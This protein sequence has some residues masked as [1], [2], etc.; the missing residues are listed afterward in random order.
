M[1][2]GGGG[3]LGLSEIGAL[4]WFEEHHIP[5]DVIAG[6]SMGGMISA[7]YA[8]GNSIDQLKAVM[9]DQ[10]FGS[11]FRI[12]TSYASRSFRRREDSRDLPNGLTI[13]LKHGV[14][15]RNSVLIDQGLNSFLDREFLR[16][17]DQVDFNTLP[18][19]FRCLSTD[20][21]EA[22]TV[23][24]ARGSIPDAVRASISIPGIY[25]PFEM[26]G[27][28]YVDGAVLQNLPAQTVR[29]DLGADVVIAVSLPLVPVGKKDLDSIVGVLQRSFSVAIEGNERA[30]RKLAD[31]VVEPDLTGFSAGDYL[32]SAEL[33]E[34]GYAAAEKMKDSLLPYAVD[35]AAWNAYLA[36][37]TAR[38]RGPAG[39]LLRVRVAAP[40]EGVT[41][42]VER[43]FAPLIDQPVATNKVESLLAA[44]RSD[45][46]YDADYTVGY[47]KGPDRRPVLL[48]TVQDKKTGP[49]FLEL[50]A[51]VAAQTGGISRATIEGILLDQDF[52]GYGS[53]LRS[54]IKLGYLTDFD[55]EY[56]RKVPNFLQIR[57]ASPVGTM[58]VAPHGGILR[59]P[60]PIYQGKTRVSERELQKAGGGVDI[61]W[62]DGRTTE[63]R[64]GWEE[65]DIRWH[66][67]IGI[68]DGL[69][70]VYGSMQRARV[71]YAL[72][73][74]D[75]AFVPQFGYRVTAEGGY[76]YDAAGGA[77]APVFD[78]QITLGHKFGKEIVAFGT[79]GGTMFGRN[80]AQPYRFT[81]G[82]PLRLSASALDELRGTDYFLVRPVIL[83]KVAS[84]PAVLGQSI[85]VGAAYEAGQ[86]RAPDFRTATRQDVFLGVLAET[87]AG[88]ISFGPALGDGGRYKLIF[89][90]GKLF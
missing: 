59:Q 69:P 64:A 30:S 81:L 61:G 63:I 37:R 54:H 67:Q 58:F 24:F 76:L 3:A 77:N 82:G 33:A 40:N 53:E 45:G 27:H 8:T 85:Y 28:E 29:N 23:T 71:R 39:T 19:P 52:G 16:Y 84:L 36:Q 13:G 14:S 15:F 25:R 12:S 43:I 2:L 20:L 26:N 86:M 70:N 11:V 79:E 55:S 73:R 80:V 21:N 41:K 46:R 5:V 1:A 68:Q 60:F 78:T 66:E 4:Q 35:D 75:K 18:I 90:L 62:T 83:R 6:T 56:F 38:K 50:G 65:N 22:R 48:V 34:R 44:I 51:N 42:N 87:P 88:V 17:D 31:V 32:K 9:N 72:D 57:P 74:Q 49:P 10:V 7:L 89:T 47:D